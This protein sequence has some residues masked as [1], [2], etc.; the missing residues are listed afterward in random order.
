MWRLTADRSAAGWQAD[1]KL[2]LQ[3]RAGN[4][5]GEIEGA[6]FGMRVISTVRHDSKGDPV[7][8][9]KI[10]VQLIS[11]AQ[12]VPNFGSFSIPGSIKA[13]AELRPGQLLV[14]GQS[15]LPGKPVV[16]FTNST[17]AKIM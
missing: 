14:I 17:P 4:E 11:G 16:E 6:H 2:A 5:E 12:Y 13:L 8:A 15:S 3:A 9:A 1:E 7:I 10:N